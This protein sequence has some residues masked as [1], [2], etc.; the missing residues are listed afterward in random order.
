MSA[1]TATDTRPGRLA[2]RRILVVGAGQQ[3]YGLED[4]PIGNGRAMSV[5]FAREGAAL[6]LAD[7]DAASVQATETLVR[8]QGAQC[9]T[10]VAD[11]AEDSGIQ[12]M[13]DGG[14]AAFGGLDGLAM[15]VGIGAGLRFKGT[16]VEDWDRVMAVNLRS[17]FLGCKHALA[18][19]EDGGTIVLI[20][21]LAGRESMPVP[22]YAASKAALEA[23]CRNAA[24][25]GAPRVRVNVLAPGLIDTSLGR[26]ATRL[27]PARGEVRIPAGRQGSAWEVARCALF[28]LSEDS[29]Y[30]TGQTLVAD[31][32]LSVATRS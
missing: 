31:G 32:G 10:V 16:S 30:V 7:I 11:A 12:A 2:G 4:P 13:F 15:N 22:A 3:D 21:S 23:V 29:S 9:V 6:A 25:E 24:A 27:N 19:F 28:L 20:G 17:H 1:G 8:E 14:R 26:M 5:L 18:S